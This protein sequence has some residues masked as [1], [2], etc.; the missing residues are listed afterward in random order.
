[1]S[2]VHGTFVKSMRKFL[3]QYNVQVLAVILGAFGGAAYYYFIGCRSGSCAIASNPYIAIP[4][5]GL[6][7]YFLA[8]IFK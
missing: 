2:P 6:M 1:M 4:Y 3:S 7:G 5:G 8:G